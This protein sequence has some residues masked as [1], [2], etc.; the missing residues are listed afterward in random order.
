M[1][2]DDPKKALT[3]GLAVGVPLELL[4]LHK[5]WVK[6]GR[7]N[8]E[9]LVLPSVELAKEGFKAHPYLVT[10]VKDHKEAMAAN[11]DLGAIFMPK[12]RAPEVGE[13]CCAGPSSPKRCSGSPRRA[14]ARCILESWLGV[15]HR[16]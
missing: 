4:G 3:G 2:V 13:F 8:W 6:Y 14:P 5:L 16:T 1:F 9:D 7:L 10:S 15:W 11:P 12:G